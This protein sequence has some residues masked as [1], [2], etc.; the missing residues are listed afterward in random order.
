MPFSGTPVENALL[1]FAY[2]QGTVRIPEMFS[3]KQEEWN[4]WARA[5]RDFWALAPGCGDSVRAA[6]ALSEANRNEVL[7]MEEVESAGHK[8]FGAILLPH[9]RGLLPKSGV[10]ASFGENTPDGGGLQLWRL[11]T[12]EFDPVQK[13]NVSKDPT[14]ATQHNQPVP[15]A[16]LTEAINSCLL[17]TSPSPRDKRQ[18]RMP[19]SA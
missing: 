1:D 19:S 16:T 8:V 4:A 3:G 7:T 17:Y 18:S 11:C 15:L 10:A 12:K 14:L 9:L 2:R 5:Y 6:L 13:A